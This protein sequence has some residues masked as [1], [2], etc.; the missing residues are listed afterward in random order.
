MNSGVYLNRKIIFQKWIV[1]SEFL[2]PAKG[3]IMNRQMA[4]LK[5]AKLYEKQA[6]ADNQLMV[7]D[8]MYNAAV[9]YFK[10]LQNYKEQEVYK[11]YEKKQDR[12]EGEKRICIG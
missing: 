5:K 2:F 11:A 7:S 10:W 9:T 1:Q 12:F 6:V 8:V 3:F 4:T